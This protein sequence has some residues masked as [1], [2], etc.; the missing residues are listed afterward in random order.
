MI[1][2]ILLCWLQVIPEVLGLGEFDT[3]CILLAEAVRH[4]LGRK[5]QNLKEQSQCL[6]D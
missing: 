6:D 2:G 4:H 1:L 5:E 3:E